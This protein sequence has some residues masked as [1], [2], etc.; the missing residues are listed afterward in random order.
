MS[1]QNQTGF[2]SELVMQPLTTSIWDQISLTATFL[3]LLWNIDRPKT[4]VFRAC[5]I[6]FY[7][8]PKLTSSLTGLYWWFAA[9]Y[10][11]LCP[12]WAFSIST[13]NSFSPNHISPRILSVL[14]FF[15]SLLCVKPGGKLMI[16]HLSLPPTNPC[17]WL[18]S[19]PEAKA[20]HCWNKTK[21]RVF[22]MCAAI[23]YYTFFI[24]SSFIS[25]HFLGSKHWKHHAEVQQNNQ[26]SLWRKQG[27]RFR[28][29]CP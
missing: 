26:A 3:Y 11:L 22:F 12:S 8:L 14:A 23:F 7:T 18:R 10:L 19:L 27:M 5:K 25:Q 1:Q 24:K 9:L 20:R 21:I 16:V 4:C 15:S 29:P 13:P 17:C 28:S 2:R 6:S